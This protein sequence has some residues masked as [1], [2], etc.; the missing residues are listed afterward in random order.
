MQYLESFFFSETR[1]GHLPIIFIAPVCCQFLAPTLPT[2]HKVNCWKVL[3][4]IFSR[5]TQICHLVDIVAIKPCFLFLRNPLWRF[6]PYNHIVV[7]FRKE[8]AFCCIFHNIVVHRSRQTVSFHV[9]LTTRH[10]DI[11]LTILNRC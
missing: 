10:I 7:S 5:L 1:T 2:L 11:D 4:N 9:S 8:V 3:L 6:L